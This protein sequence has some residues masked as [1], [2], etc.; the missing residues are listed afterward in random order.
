MEGKYVWDPQHVVHKQYRNVCTSYQE[1]CDRE[2][3]ALKQGLLSG[4]TARDEAE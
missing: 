2:Q 4:E 1:D 3:A